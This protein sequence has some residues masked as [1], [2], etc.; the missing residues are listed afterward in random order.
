MRSFGAFG[1]RR[2]RT[3]LTVRPGIRASHA[4]SYARLRVKHSA[5]PLSPNVEGPR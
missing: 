4:R 2:W 1:L 3:K 5:A